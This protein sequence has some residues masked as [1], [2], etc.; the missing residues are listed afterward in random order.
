MSKLLAIAATLKAVLIAASFALARGDMLSIIL[1]SALFNL[2]HL[3][4]KPPSERCSA[5]AW[6][7][8]AATIS[9]P[10]DLLN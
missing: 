9:G 8:R 1:I 10:L 6:W 7:P 4:A 3:G 5:T 2:I